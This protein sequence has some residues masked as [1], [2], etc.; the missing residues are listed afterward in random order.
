MAETSAIVQKASE[1]IAS[2]FRE[3]LSEKYVYHNVNHTA[4]VV[5]ACQ[6]IGEGAKLSAD[7]L[8]IVLLAAWFHDAGFVE[9]SNG[10]E[11]KSV[12]IAI[13]FLQENGY[14]QENIDKVVGCIRAT[15]MPQSPHNLLEEVMCD[16]DLIHLGKK[17]Y[18]DRSALMRV[19]WE[20]ALGKTYT[21]IEWL[22]SNM[23]FF[24][25]HRFHTAYAQTEFSQR[26][27]KSLAKLE[28]QLQTLMAETAVKE[29]KPKDKGELSPKKLEKL[30][31]EKKP[32]RGTETMFRVTSHNHITLS[33]MA[34]NKANTVISINT[35]IIGIMFSLLVPRLVEF[36]RL[37]IP[38]LILLAVC[39]TAII[40]ATIAT[41]PQ[42]TSGI[43][44]REDIQQKRTNLLFFGNFHKM[45]LEDFE[46]G[47][48]EMMNDRDYLYGS[49]IKDI[50]FLGKVLGKKYN[51]LRISYNIFM[52][53]LV[54]AVIAFIIAF[55]LP[56]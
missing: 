1:Y 8:E 53:G 30:E 43:F 10:H 24:R 46:W 32:E 12:D 18:F 13:R 4:E 14:P 23:E 48:K 50:Y 17:R 42:I 52:Y 34:D 2:L 56:A 35:L 54:L 7:D 55:V 47:L 6:E 36:P 38:T 16:A 26:H 11:E 41:R 28:E 44:T 33:S 51:Y 29:A 39:L 20:K 19:E 25:K 9:T 3:R 15:K 22:N 40:F 31:K 49:M 27:S 5:E 37:V 45:Q 21:D